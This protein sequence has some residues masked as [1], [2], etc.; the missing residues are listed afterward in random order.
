[1]SRGIIATARGMS[2]NI[3]ELIQQAQRPIGTVDAASTREKPNYTPAVSNT[4]KVRGFVP[5]RGTAPAP[6]HGPEFEGDDMDA[7]VKQKL[8]KAKPQGA[9]GKKAL[10][11]MT[12]V[13]VKETPRIRAAIEAATAQ[14][15]VAA[16]EDEVLGSIISEMD[17]P[18]T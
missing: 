12:G 1:M 10:A 2:L 11:E 13:T 5:G 18:S 4:P 8:T 16:E 14:P 17:K 7:T 15:S 9:G 6:A 3:D